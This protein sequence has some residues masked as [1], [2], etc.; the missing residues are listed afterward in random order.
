MDTNKAIIFINKGL[1]DIANPK[2]IINIT[3]QV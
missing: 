2:T 1:S 3:A